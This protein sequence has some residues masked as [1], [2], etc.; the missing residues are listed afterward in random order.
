MIVKPR[1]KG[2]VCI[3]SHPLGCMA[4]V[5]QQAELA[6]LNKIGTDISVKRALIIGASTGYGLS[7]RIVSAYSAGADTLGVYFERPPKEDKPASAGFYNSLAFNELTKSLN[8]Q[9]IDVNGDAFSNECK[10]EV[11]EKAKQLG[12]AFD[13]VIYSLASPRRTDPE[14]GD[15]FRACL[16]PIGA[17]Y[18]NKTLDTDR[19][20]VKEVTIDPANDDE[21]EHTRKVMGGEDWKLWTELLLRENLLA[22]GCVNLAY[23]YIGPE[24]TQPIYR[25]GTIGRAKEDLESSAG[26]ISALMRKQCNGK[27]FVSVNK[28]VVTQA[29]SAIPVVPLYVS[30]LFKVMRE[31]GTHEGCIEQIIRMFN[32]RLF[33]EDETVPVDDNGRIRLDDWE[34]DPVIQKEVIRAWGSIT[35]EN[36]LETT[37]FKEYQEEFLKLFGFGFDEVDYT[38]EVDLINPF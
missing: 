22:E 14:S 30:L 19:K 26:E 36:L 9:H 11:V 5:K 25:N 32:E 33:T 6:A 27:A 7:S 31:Q 34:M 24:V 4:S 21:I 16:K 29:S 17:V 28:A 3:T 1:I 23:S 18:R 20:E 2:F 13:L 8:S 37:N 12:G 38:K 15:T 35:T 10:S